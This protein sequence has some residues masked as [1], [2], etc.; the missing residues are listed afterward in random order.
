MKM[1]LYHL[2]SRLKAAPTSQKNNRFK[3]AK[4][5]ARSDG[6]FFQASGPGSYE[7]TC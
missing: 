5:I 1:E 2:K 3:A 7:S 4:F 6:P